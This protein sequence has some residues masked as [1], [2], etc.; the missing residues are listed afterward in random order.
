MNFRFREE[1]R[2]FFFFLISHSLFFL[3]LSLSLSKST[4]ATAMMAA[5]AGDLPDWLD[6]ED[7]LGGDD[8]GAFLEAKK[9]RACGNQSSLNG[10][11]CSP[12]LSLLS[13]NQS[14]KQLF[15]PLPMLK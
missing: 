14:I 15:L 7:V 6:A 2:F 5:D 8:E 4:M 11:R 10:H 9:K 3:F 1:R 12:P 13:L